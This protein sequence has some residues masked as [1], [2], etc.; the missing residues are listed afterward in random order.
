MQDRSHKL[1]FF[2]LTALMSAVVFY[3]SEVGP[4]L[5]SGDDMPVPASS[6]VFTPGEEQDVS[7]ITASSNAPIG[8]KVAPDG[9]CSAEAS[10]KSPLCLATSKI[11]LS[12]R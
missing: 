12:S 8:A 7:N 2:G 9:A 6:A 11:S 4:T 3:G 1:V 10:E 5:L